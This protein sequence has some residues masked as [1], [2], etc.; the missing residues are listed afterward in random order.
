MAQKESSTFKTD[1]PPHLY[2]VILSRPT[3][4]SITISVLTDKD[5]NGYI[6]YGSDKNKLNKKSTPRQFKQAI[7]TVIELDSLVPDTRYF[8]QLIYTSND[9][10]ATQHSETCYFRPVE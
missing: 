9:Q 10:A 2:D 7:T 8:Y 1:I 5:L 4:H 3:D 6:Q